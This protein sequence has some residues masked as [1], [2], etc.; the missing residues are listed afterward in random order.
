MSPML[1]KC[2]FAF[3]LAC[4]CNVVSRTAP[5]RPKKPLAMSAQSIKIRKVRASC[6]CYVQAW[7]A[8]QKE[9]HRRGIKLCRSLCR[10]HTL[11]RIQ[12]SVTTLSTS[13]WKEWGFITGVNLIL[14]AYNT[15]LLSVEINAALAACLYH[16]LRKSQ[17]FQKEWQQHGAASSL[18]SFTV[19][20]IVAWT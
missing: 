8:L 1:R 14:K 9:L 3:L 18:H 20:R 6:V 16:F 5:A 15:V 13:Y 11:K 19:Q 12:A 17:S 10:T 2:L 7:A 4:T